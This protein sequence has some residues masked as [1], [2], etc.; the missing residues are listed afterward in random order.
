MSH[1][2]DGH[3]LVPDQERITGLAQKSFLAHG[4][5]GLVIA[6]HCPQQTQE[7]QVR[8]ATDVPFLVPHARVFARAF[9]EFRHGKV[10]RC[11][12]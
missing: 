3:P 4:S 7:K 5:V 6:V 1:L 12:T 10:R 9:V 8:H 11:R 2:I